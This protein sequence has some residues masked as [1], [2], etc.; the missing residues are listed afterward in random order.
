MNFLGIKQVSS[1]YF[2]L[3]NH[4]LITFTGISNSLDLA[5]IT[6]RHRGYHAKVHETQD[7]LDRTTG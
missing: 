2:H 7:S 5:P 3:K 6:E 4:F 1:I